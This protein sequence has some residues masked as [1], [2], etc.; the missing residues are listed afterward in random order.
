MTRE[1]LGGLGL[2]QLGGNG[3]DVLMLGRQRRDAARFEGLLQVAEV[4]EGPAD[5]QLRL[6]L[7]AGALTHLIEPV[8]HEIQ[9]QVVLVDAGGVQSEHAHLAGT[10]S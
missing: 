1:D 2:R 8:V 10:G 6:P 3:A 9:L 4:G 7:L 5:D